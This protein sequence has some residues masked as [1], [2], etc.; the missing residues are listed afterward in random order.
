MS[1]LKNLND[2]EGLPRPSDTPSSSS[3]DGSSSLLYDVNPG[4]HFSPG[5]ALEMKCE[6]PT[7]KLTRSDLSS[8]AAGGDEYLRLCTPQNPELV[9]TR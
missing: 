5:E 1:F 9:T 2:I 4:F 3:T 8:G 6:C 7:F